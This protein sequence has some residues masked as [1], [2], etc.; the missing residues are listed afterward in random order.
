MSEQQE[1]S[2]LV[3]TVFGAWQGARINFLVL[4]NYQGLPQF[5]DNDID[6]LVEPDQLGRAEEV[7]LTAAQDAGFRLHNRAEFATLALYLSSRNSTAQAHFD[8]FTALKWRGFD[9]RGCQAF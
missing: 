7:L 5:T 4:R 9:F 3:T 2:H 8:L 6:V 1:I